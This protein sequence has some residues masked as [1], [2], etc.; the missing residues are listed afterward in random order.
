VTVTIPTARLTVESCPQS[1]SWSAAR[2][3][4]GWFDRPSD[5]H[6]AIGSD[7]T[8]RWLGVSRAHAAAAI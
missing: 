1:A 6:P 3:A 7:Q 5:A 4:G 8:G 2:M